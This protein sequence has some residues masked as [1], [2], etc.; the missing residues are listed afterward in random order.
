MDADPVLAQIDSLFA[1]WGFAP[2]AIPSWEA[3]RQSSSSE[4]AQ[5]TTRAMALLERFAPRSRYVQAAQEPFEKG[6]GESSGSET[7][8]VVA[9]ALAAFRSDV[10]D[11]YLKTWAELIHAD[12]FADFLEMA[13]EL[14]EKGFKDPAAVIAGSVLEE[15]LRK[16]AEANEIPTTKPSGEPLKASVINADLT[17]AGVYNKLVE[18]SVTAWL[19]LRNSAAHGEYG[20]YDNAQVAALIRDVRDFMVRNPA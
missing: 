2:D 18:K 9:A 3:F 15:H 5:R 12:V 20:N 17:K 19:S 4:I 1:E 8:V 13:A 7:F 10:R 16:L 6:W 11:G 14:Q